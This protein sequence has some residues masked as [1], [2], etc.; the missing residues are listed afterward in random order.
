MALVAP[1]R[2]KQARRDGAKLSKS[3]RCL[4]IV[5][6]SIDLMFASRMA[7]FTTWFHS[8]VLRRLH[9]LMKTAF[10]FALTKQRKDKENFSW[11]QF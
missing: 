3:D 11:Q 7:E 1:R 5:G 8:H 10:L 2:N 9:R 6:S 4:P